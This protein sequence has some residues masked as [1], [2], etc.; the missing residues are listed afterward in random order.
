MPKASIQRAV[1]VY[2]VAVWLFRASPRL[3]RL[4]W[5]VYAW[6]IYLAASSVPKDRGLCGWAVLLFLLQDVLLFLWQASSGR[7]ELFLFR[8]R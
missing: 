8:A 7:P 4:A 6:V 1:G 3:R 2:G 5:T